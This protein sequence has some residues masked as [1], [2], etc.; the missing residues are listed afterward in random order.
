MT[1]GLPQNGELHYL[2]FPPDAVT[3]LLSNTEIRAMTSLNAKEH[4]IATEFDGW[5]VFN[6]NKKP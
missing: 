1:S 2:K 4:L 3:T 5:Y 6:S